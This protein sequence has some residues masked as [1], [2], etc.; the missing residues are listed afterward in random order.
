[1]SQRILNDLAKRLDLKIQRDMADFADLC[2]RAD[3]DKD[4]TTNHLITLM[5]REALIGMITIGMHKKEILAAVGK[6]HDLIRPTL[7]RQLKVMRDE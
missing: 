2:D 4:D 6:A 3:C 7:E 5:V 1:M